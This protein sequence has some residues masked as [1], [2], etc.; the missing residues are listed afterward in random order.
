VRRPARVPKDRSGEACFRWR[1]GD[2]SRLEGLTGGV[3][4]LALIMLSAAVP[5]NSAELLAF[6]A[7]F[8]LL[9]MV[10]W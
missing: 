5:R 3:S 4:A 6:A 1:G 2:A 8:A 7:T 9:A 10:G